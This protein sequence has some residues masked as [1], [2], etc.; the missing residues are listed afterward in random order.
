MSQDTSRPLAPRLSRRFLLQS[1][2]LTALVGAFSGLASPLRAEEPRRGGSL[3]MNIGT[4]P[5]VLL[6]LAHTAGAATYIS[7]KTTEGLLTYDFDF[8]PKPLLATE[9]TVSPDGLRYWFRLREGVKFHDGTPF[10]AEDVKFS[11]ET[12][13]EHHPRGR[14]TYAHVTAVN[15]LGP[16]EIELLLDQPAPYLLTALASFESPIVPKHIY[17]GKPILENP[18][19]SAPIGTGPFLFKEWVRGSHVLFV[20]NPDYWDAGK[21][22][23]DQLVV[24]FVGDA[25]A[26]AAGLETGEIQL[27]ANAPVPLSDIA[28]LQE[29]PRLGFETR[30]YAFTN[31]ISRAEFN[32]ER[33]H[34]AD[35]RV[36]QAVAHVVDRDFIVA[37]AYQGHATPLYGPVSHTLEKFFIPDLPRYEIDT[38][39]AEALLEEAGYPR[40]ADG[41]RFSLVIDPT[42]P[43]GPPKLSADYIAQVLQS[44]GIKAEVRTQ[45][46]ATFVKRVYT[47]RDFDI[48]VE[49]MANLFDPTVGIQRLYWSKN[50]KPGVPFTNGAK[51]ASERTDKLLEEAAVEIDP[52]KRF[53][54]FAEFQKQVIADLPALDLV[55]PTAYTIYDKRVHNH[56]IGAEGLNA[57]GAELWVAEG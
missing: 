9:W 34:L 39:K 41:W 45:D 43:V 49:G 23:L 13:K 16:H 2:A 32:F 27:S 37:A 3:T 55:S 6:L 10:T 47:D 38:A 19:N 26:G 4:E 20:R 54:L 1:A 56:T 29:N 12:L 14:A 46:F 57:N 44:I 18:N 42:Q 17:E 24:R 21:P 35:L 48:A 30:G 25:A 53:D 28:R 52:K 5:P 22:Y 36:R 51:Y 7:G 8:T 33:P 40:G 31:S 15:V 50:F 11:I